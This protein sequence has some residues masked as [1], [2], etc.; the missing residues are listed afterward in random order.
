MISGNVIENPGSL[1]NLG[2]NHNHWL[3]LPNGGS[4]DD[5]G[6]NPDSAGII[7][8]CFIQRRKD[9]DG[10]MFIDDGERVCVGSLIGYAIIPVE[11]YRALKTTPQNKP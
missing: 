5:R 6:I 7:S 2:V 11:Q 9:Q 1:I 4:A 8:S 3:A 10:P